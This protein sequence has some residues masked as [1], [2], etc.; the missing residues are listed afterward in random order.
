MHILWTY[1]TTFYTG[2]QTCSILAWNTIHSKAPV[3]VTLLLT[4]KYILF[5]AWTT[6][7]CFLKA[8]NFKARS[9]LILLPF[10]LLCHWLLL[11]I[12]LFLQ[13]L[14]RMFSIHIKYGLKIRPTEWGGG[15]IYQGNSCIRRPY[16][17]ERKLFPFLS[18]G[19]L[20]PQWIMPCKEFHRCRL[21][22][23]SLVWGLPINCTLYS[24]LDSFNCVGIST[25][26]QHN[27]Q[28]QKTRSIYFTKHPWSTW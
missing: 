14:K 5:S 25:R 26:S 17:K 15:N 11:L 4:A 2:E 28:Q 24:S 16:R 3:D 8:E 27:W 23:I 20:W 10:L 6:E 21:P 19:R 9:S 12:L 7:A 22:V 18:C 1:I 13:I